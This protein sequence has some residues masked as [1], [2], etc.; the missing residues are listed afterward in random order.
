M[1]NT[2]W[3]S[4]FKNYGSGALTMFIYFDLVISLETIRKK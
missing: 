2:N 1:E 4:L 3:H